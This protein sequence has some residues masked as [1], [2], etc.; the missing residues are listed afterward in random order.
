MDAFD[1]KSKYMEN[2]V[3]FH[4][5]VRV[6]APK[7]EGGSLKGLPYSKTAPMDPSPDP[8]FKGCLLTLCFEFALFGVTSLIQ[9]LNY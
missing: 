6:V 5:S 9:L 3:I 7:S 8:A 1:G 4:D 2:H